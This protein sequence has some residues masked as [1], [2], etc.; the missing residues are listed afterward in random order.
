MKLFWVLLVF[1]N[2]QQ[3]SEIAF[4]DLDTCIE[5]ATKISKQNNVQVI[6]GSSYINA[7]CIPRKREGN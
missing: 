3:V 5:Y 1:I 6:A 4:S 7:L 2:N